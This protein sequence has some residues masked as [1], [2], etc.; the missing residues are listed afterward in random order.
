MLFVDTVGKEVKK[1]L[2]DL[3]EEGVVDWY[4]EASC[5]S[6]KD[7]ELQSEKHLK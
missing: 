4:G 3:E 6:D 2:G 7:I 1:R 5:W